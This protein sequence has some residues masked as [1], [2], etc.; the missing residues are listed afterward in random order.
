MG[1][2]SGLLA[3]AVSGGAQAIQQ[4][5]KSKIEEM[6]EKALMELKEEMQSTRDDR[7]WGREQK[8]AQ[9]QAQA[10]ARNR[11]EDR[12]WELAD[13]ETKQDNALQLQE[14]RNAGRAGVGGARTPSRIVEAR[15]LMQEDPDKYP[16]FSTAYGLVRSS[17]G[18]GT[19]YS[20]ATDR[21]DYLTGQIDNLDKVLNDYEARGQY[22]EDQIIDME[23]RRDMLFQDL[24]GAEQTVYRV[25]S[26]PHASTGG[27]S[28]KGLIPGG[29][30]TKPPS[31]GDQ[32]TGSWGADDPSR[33][34]DEFLNK[35]LN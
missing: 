30:S 15:M 10:D 16:D 32:R 1:A 18:Q 19:D 29:G 4:N 35:F 31:S 12:Q 13:M 3:G 8:L 14:V 2:L 20:Q 23:D 11:T 34:A 26:T 7:S 22:S 17:A 33:E 25:G 5:A 28:G 24:Q 6:R 21:I 9:Q 27:G